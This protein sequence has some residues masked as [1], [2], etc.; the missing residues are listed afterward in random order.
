MTFISDHV[1]LPASYSRNSSVYLGLDDMGH[2]CYND[3]TSQ[4][5]YGSHL[6]RD[7]VDTGSHRASESFAVHSG[8]EDGENDQDNEDQDGGF[9]ESRQVWALF[10]SSFSPLEMSKRH[11]STVYLYLPL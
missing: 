3:T 10:Y 7:F 8:F 9:S 5:S 2:G 1:V 6:N 11:H 4:I